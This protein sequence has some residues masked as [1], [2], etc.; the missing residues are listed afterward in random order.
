MWIRPAI[1]SLAARIS[2]DCWRNRSTE[3]PLAM[4]KLT[5][6]SVMQMVC[7]PRATAASAISNT[8]CLPS[9]HVVCMCKSAT[10]S[11]CWMSCGSCPACAASISPLSSRNTGGI[12]GKPRVA[13]TSSSVAHKILSPVATFVKAYSFKLKPCFW[14]ISRR[15]MLCAW[16][17]VK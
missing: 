10:M 11:L 16:L 8:L 12:K 2:A 14:A 4:P 13:Y 1:C 17:P 9:D 15:R 6:W 3:S 5:E 7:K